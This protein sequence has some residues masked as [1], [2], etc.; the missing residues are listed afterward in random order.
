MHIGQKGHVS[1][2]TV[3]QLPVCTAYLLPVPEQEEQAALYFPF[4][5]MLCVVLLPTPT[6]GTVDFLGTTRFGKT[7]PFD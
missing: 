5:F 1:T 6:F 2:S 4:G 3:Y 7:N